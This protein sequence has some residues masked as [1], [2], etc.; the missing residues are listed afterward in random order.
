MRIRE[1]NILVCSE[2]FS[3]A[4]HVQFNF[5]KKVPQIKV[6]TEQE[7]RSFS[8]SFDLSYITLQSENKARS[9]WGLQMAQKELGSQAAAISSTQSRSSEATVACLLLQLTRC[10]FIWKGNSSLPPHRK[11]LSTFY[12]GLTLLTLKQ[13]KSLKP[14]A[15]SLPEALSLEPASWLFGGRF[16]PLMRRAQRSIWKEPKLARKANTHSFTPKCSET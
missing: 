6:P 13:N 5:L 14:A 11:T 15:R 8:G 16:L 2:C 1:K 12:R 4:P 9:R 10:C 7:K 3:R